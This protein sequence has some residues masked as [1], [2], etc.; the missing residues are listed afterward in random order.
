MVGYAQDC[1]EI[2][3]A[4]LKS[5][6]AND[7]LSSCK[8]IYNLL[9]QCGFTIVTHILGNEAPLTL[10][11]FINESN[12]KFQLNP[13]HVHRHNIAEQAIQ[14][15][16]DHF[17]EG[18][19]STH[20]DFPLHLWFR[21]LPQA[22]V[23][24]NLLLPSNTHPQLSFHCHLFGPFNYRYTPLAPPGLPVLAHVKPNQWQTWDLHSLDGWYLGHAP[25]HYRCHRVY[26]NSHKSERNF[27]TME[28][29]S[30]NDDILTVTDDQVIA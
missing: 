10:H 27:D 19:R 23:T 13:P 17:I 4:P 11:Q 9:I 12:E 25:N 20:Q 5:R 26:V 1:N 15:F 24:L 29:L 14:T 28:F 30:H 7:L 16:K 8:N 21:L 2:L 6:S 18:L 3:S 22:I